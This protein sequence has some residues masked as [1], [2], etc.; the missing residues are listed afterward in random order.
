LNPGGT[1][2]CTVS[3]NKTVQ[4]DVI[5]LASNDP[6]IVV[7]SS[8]SLSTRATSATFKATA[9]YGTANGTVAR[10]SASISGKTATTDFNIVVPQLLSLSC[11][12]TTLA[13]NTTTSCTI[14]VSAAASTAMSVILRS[15]S[16]KLLRVPNSVTI[17]TGSSSAKFPLRASNSS[18]AATVTA[19]WNGLKTSV[20]ISVP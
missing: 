9:S 2:S 17:Q 7:P 5:Q 3:L 15:D 12:S 18:G 13:Q 16:D 14:K 10:V 19:S 8:L 4:G 20:L 1:S 6:A 11:D